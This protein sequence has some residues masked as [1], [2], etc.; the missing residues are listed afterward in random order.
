LSYVAR[1]R[2]GAHRKKTEHDP[3]LHF[4]SISTPDGTLILVDDRVS[5]TQSRER[6]AD[7]PITHWVVVAANPA[8]NR[9]KD[10][11]KMTI[12]R[13]VAAGL[14]GLAL[15]L[16]TVGGVVAVNAASPLT[17]PPAIT[18][19]A[20]AD[21]KTADGPDMGTAQNP[22]G[23]A[24]TPDTP[25]DPSTVK[26]TTDQV[27]A[28]ALAKFPGGT[29]G[30]AELQDENGVVIWGVSVTDASGHLQEI[31]VDATTGATGAS[32]D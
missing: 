30:K 8:V 13:K 26:I 27:K 21:A 29:V 19:P 15:M 17:A 16:G 32:G 25:I 22:E 31:T 9:V 1:F 7:H 6:S 10:G 23:A 2:G 3:V 24:E 14:G 20:Q 12:R 5:R 18:Q 28:A 11:M 4:I